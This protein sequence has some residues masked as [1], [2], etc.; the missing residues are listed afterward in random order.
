MTKHRI[1]ILNLGCP[2][3]IADAENILGRLADKG[4]EITD[5][6]KADS[7]IINTCAFIDEAKKESIDAILDLISLKKEGKLKK[8]VVAGCLAQRFKDE[9]RRELPE[10]DA[11]MGRIALNHNLRRFALTPK[12]YAYLKICEG[13]VNNCNYCIIP[14][15]KGKFSSLDINSVLRKVEEFDR[16]RVSELNIIG[17]DISGYG[18]DLYGRRRLP[19]LLQ[20][21]VKKAK[22][23]G[24]IRLLYLYPDALIEELL[25]LMKDQ[26]KIC[27]YID[28]PIQHINGRLL[29]L[30]NRK[31]NKRTI[32]EL[33][34]KIRKSLPD[35]A[36]RTSLIVGFPS[37]TDK[38]F[39]ELLKF[40]EDEKFERLG[41]FIYSREEGTPAYDFKP[42]VPHRIKIERLNAVM[43]AQQ[44]ISQELNKRLLGKV[45]DVL[46][47]EKKTDCYLGRS[48]IDA[49]E[50]D[51]LVYV[52]SVKSDLNA[53]DFLK[54]KITDTLEY[55]LVGE[56]L[57]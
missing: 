14:K 45:I 5:I 53:G 4:Y 21:V 3:N 13:C 8:I 40:I 34:R 11:F 50:V 27:R 6:D 25:D 10:V 43:S 9:L 2:R 12:H 31:M 44:K 18:I 39:G 57:K 28:L 56:A 37:E 35:V 54:V 47:D 46:I 19:E 52:S 7:A 33:I 20:K 36:I 24:W 32:R 17:Q 1:G 23:I 15:I 41:A 38:E 51:G 29:K 22:H 26:P 30:M 16:E 55:D 42:Q 48:Q 49:P